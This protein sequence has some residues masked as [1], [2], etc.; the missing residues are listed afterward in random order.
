MAYQPKV[1]G[2]CHVSDDGGTT[3]KRL[4]N[5]TALTFSGGDRPENTNDTLDEGS[6]VTV[7]APV[8]KDVS[9]S[10]QANPASEGYKAVFK[11]YKDE[12][13][14]QLRYQTDVKSVIDNATSSHTLAITA[15][16]GA[17]TASAQVK[18]TTNS[19]FQV[20]RGIVIANTLYI[21]ESITNDTTGVVSRADGAAI[22]AVAA[23]DGWEIVEFGVQHQME[24]EV[25]SAGNPDL[26]PGAA[27]A[28]TIT[29]KTTGV[30]SDPTFLTP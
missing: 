14:L 20:G 22:T 27:Y 15:S 10:L 3:W 6:V 29:L 2:K 16:T 19:N 26:S 1:E 17:L 7:G 12:A 9:I 21:I 18:L 4:L 8:Q 30:M 23:T 25:I 11:A 5:L 24:V 28:D 13:K